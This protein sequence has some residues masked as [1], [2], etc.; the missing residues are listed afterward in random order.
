LKAIVNRQRSVIVDV[1]EP[2]LRF[3]ASGDDGKIASQALAKVAEL[4]R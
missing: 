3:Y 1:L 2:A 4:R